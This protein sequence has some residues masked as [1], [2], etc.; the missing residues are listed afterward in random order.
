MRIVLATNNAHKMEEIARVL[1]PAGA[2]LILPA[3]LGLATPTPNPVEDGSTYVE[4]AT[5]KARA[6][7]DWSSLPALADDSGLEVDALGGEPGLYSSRFAGALATAEEN[8][9]QILERLQG[10]ELERRTARFICV[11]VWIEEDRVR[12]EFTGVCEGKIAL[13]ERGSEGFGYDPIFIPDG[14]DRSFAEMTQAEKDSQSHRGLALADLRRA[15]EKHIPR[16]T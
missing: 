14:E 13:E 4:N 3:S 15:W 9:R 11:L 6:F 5:I 1:G 12:G 10:V 7:A 8:R 16:T 2:G